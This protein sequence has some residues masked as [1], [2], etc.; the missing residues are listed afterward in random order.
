MNSYSYIY[1]S[2]RFVRKLLVSDGN[3]WKYTTVQII[4]IYVYLQRIFIISNWNHMIALNTRNHII[5]CHQMV[6]NK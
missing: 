2:D 5:S 1:G 6:M 4:G 3:T